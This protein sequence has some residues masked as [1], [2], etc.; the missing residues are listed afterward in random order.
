MCYTYD[1]ES[2]ILVHNADYDAIAK[3]GFDTNQQTIIKWAKEYKKTGISMDDAE[4]LVDLAKQYNKNGMLGNP[5]IDLIHEGRK[6]Y[7]S[8]RP[9]VHIGPINHIKI[10]G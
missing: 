9:H 10:I 2:A 8:N 6:G 1:T 3:I 5:R 4:A 7:F